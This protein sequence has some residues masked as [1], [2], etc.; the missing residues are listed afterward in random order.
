MRIKLFEQYYEEELNI[1]HGSPK[2]FDEFKNDDI[3]SNT[4]QSFHGWGLYFIDSKKSAS[5]YAF[6]NDLKNKEGYLYYVNIDSIKDE[7]LVWNEDIPQDKIEI[8]A[9]QAIKEGITTQILLDKV[10]S[11][12][13][14][15][16]HPDN[17]FMIKGFEELADE[18][19]ADKVYLKTTTFQN[20][21][22]KYPLDGETLYENLSKIFGSDEQASKFL[23]RCGIKGMSYTEDNSPTV[24]VIYDYK[25]IKI[26]KK[27]FIKNE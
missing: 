9:K 7:L 12:D 14:N 10:N 5:R 11:V 27:E 17:K 24:Y 25:L 6:N 23:L 8:M 4:N 15:I 20:I 2:S 18:Y 16:K 21:R 3:G 19:G 1:F 13:I 26:T 22:G